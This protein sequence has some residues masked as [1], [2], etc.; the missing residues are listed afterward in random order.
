MDSIRLRRNCS[1]SDL[2]WLDAGK[3]QDRLLARGYSR[4]CLRRA[5]NKTIGQSRQKLLFQSKSKKNSNFDPMRIIMRYSSQH[6]EIRE[7]IKKQWSILIDDQRIQ[8]FI[9][10]NPLITYKPASSIKDK[11]GSERI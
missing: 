4:S 6:T 1:N 8:Q 9:S 5:Y 2:F 7:N 3:L 11:T 10:T